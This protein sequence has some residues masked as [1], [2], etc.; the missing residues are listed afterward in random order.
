MPKAAQRGAFWNLLK[1]T[2][3][4]LHIGRLAD[5]FKSIIRDEAFLFDLGNRKSFTEGAMHI[6]LKNVTMGSVV[7]ISMHNRQII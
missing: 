7:N 1:N 5:D 4:F 3:L 6:V 2:L